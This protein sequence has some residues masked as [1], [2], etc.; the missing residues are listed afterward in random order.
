V[1]CNTLTAYSLSGTGFI[2][3]VTLLQVSILVTFH[4]IP[5][6]S[7]LYQLKMPDTSKKSNIIFRMLQLKTCF[8]D[9]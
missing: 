3:A 2:T 8:G 9:K 4:K 6:V 1:I 5:S 7:F